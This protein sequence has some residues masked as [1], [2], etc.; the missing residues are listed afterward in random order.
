MF[1]FLSTGKKA[2][3]W[4]L[5]GKCR[6]LKKF[7]VEL[8][9][10]NSGDYMICDIQINNSNCFVPISEKSGK[11]VVKSR[12]VPLMS[13]TDTLKCIQVIIF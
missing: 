11:I 5:K 9:L 8:K 3:L 12:Q 6:L 13:E 10:T 1:I 4:C 2:R 7:H